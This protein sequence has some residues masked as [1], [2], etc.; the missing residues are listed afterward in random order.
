MVS[1]LTRA[2]WHVRGTR[3]S[4]GPAIA[5]ADILT[6]LE[7]GPSTDWQ[8]ALNG[9][10]AVVHL[11]AR[12]H[13]SKS[14]QQQEK[15]LYFS[16][17][18]EGTMAMLEFAQKQGESHARP[19]TFLYPSSIAAYGLPSLDAKSKA[20]KVREDDFNHPTTMYGC[21]KLYCEL[22]GDYYAKHYKQLSADA[23]G[24][25]TRICSFRRNRRSAVGASLFPVDGPRRTKSAPV[26]SGATG[27]VS[28]ATSRDGIDAGPARAPTRN[29]YSPGPR[30][31]DGITATRASLPH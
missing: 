30:G 29:T 4:V 7:L 24:I 25:S 9:V 23:I 3:R 31:C 27:T 1:A 10:R 11:A 16:V 15:D 13:R 14:T 8:A 19:V 20:G 18:V 6:G 2:G 28:R 22:L 26:A 12:A 17:N 5:S 21:N